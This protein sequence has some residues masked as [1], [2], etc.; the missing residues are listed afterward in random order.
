MVLAQEPSSV[1]SIGTAEMFAA[2]EAI[3]ECK[4]ISWNLLVICNTTIPLVIPLDSRDPFTSLSTQRNRAEKSICCDVNVERHEFQRKFIDHISWIPDMENLPEPGTKRDSP[5]I[6]VLPVIMEW[7]WSP[8]LVLRDCAEPLQP[9]VAR[10]SRQFPIKRKRGEYET[11][12]RT[13]LLPSV[14]SLRLGHS[15]VPYSSASLLTRRQ[16]SQNYAVF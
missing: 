3:D 14:R 7:Y 13:T 2:G 1:K 12:D 16:C 9:L 5:L 4:M 10:V 15:D 8:A 6:D 11:Y